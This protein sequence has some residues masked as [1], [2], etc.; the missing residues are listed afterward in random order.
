[1]LNRVWR[2][3]GVIYV[4]HTRPRIAVGLLVPE[5]ED[6]EIAIAAAI[7]PRYPIVTCREGKRGRTRLVSKGVRVRAHVFLRGLGV[8]LKMESREVAVFS[9]RTRTPRIRLSSLRCGAQTS[10]ES[11]C[12]STA[13]G[14]VWEIAPPNPHTHTRTPTSR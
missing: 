13:A 4:E 11:Q 5:I 14:H 1:V 9:G 10:E 7:R 8:T 2:N 12:A 3:G 6:N